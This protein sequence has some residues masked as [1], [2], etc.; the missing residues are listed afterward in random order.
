MMVLPRR[1]TPGFHEVTV[2][3][4][5]YMSD[6]VNF[7]SRKSA[8]ACLWDQLRKD[9]FCYV[10]GTGISRDLC[11]AALHVTR[12]FLHHADESVRRSCLTKDR[13]R[14]GYSPMC[15]ENFASLVGEEGPNDL[16]RKYRVGPL[17]ARG[18]SSL[19]APNVWPEW[20]E[21][22]AFQSTVQKYYQ[23]ANNVAQ[24]VIRA[25]GDMILT[26]NSGLG[27]S[28]RVFQKP[29]AI[30]QTSI[31]TL[32]G[33]RVGS[34]HKRQPPE[35]L[36]APH[37]DV[38]VITMLFFDSGGCATLQ[39]AAGGGWTDV[40]L[41]SDITEDPIFVVNIGDCL[42]ELCS[43]LLPST[44]HQVMPTSRADPRSCLALFV[45]LHPDE[46]LTLPS[47]EQLCYEDWRKRRIAR[48]QSVLNKKICPK[49]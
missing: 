6:A 41:P 18:E 36:I 29:N 23:E 31:L 13:A 37:T 34:R 30:A 5:S 8:A 46:E 2:D 12:Q 32:L 17:H 19:L 38:G 48:A 20:E 35:S 10:S 7:E 21:A 24:A 15:T 16:V 9:G 44:L 22:P 3:I 14:R 28:M 1:D 25:I 49:R 43:G 4:S 40:T 27:L 45:G 42:S 11:Q 47:G 39:R 33:Y 26:Q